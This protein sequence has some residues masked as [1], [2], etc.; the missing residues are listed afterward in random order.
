MA[1]SLATASQVAGCSLL[2]TWNSARRLTPNV[3][4]AQLILRVTTQNHCEFRSVY[5]EPL[6]PE[7]RAAGAY[8]DELRRPSFASGARQFSDRAY[9]DAANTGWRDLRGDLDG[10]IHVD[11]LNQIEARQ[12]LLGFSER[13]IRDGHFSMA[14]SHRGSGTNGLKGFRGKAST[15]VPER[16]IVGH[17]PVVG[18]SPNFLLFTVDKA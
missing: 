15:C 8:D 10:V 14:D 5:G 1:P 11:G 3:D 16:L 2:P 13:A 4:Q 17:A 7:V 12:T 18:H 9:L 6:G